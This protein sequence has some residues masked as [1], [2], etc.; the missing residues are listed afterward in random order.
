MKIITKIFNLSKSFPLFLLFISIS[1]NYNYFLIAQAERQAVNTKIQGSAA[2]IAKKAMV[3]IDE[4]LREEYPSS[5]VI[6]PAPRPRRKLRNS[7][8]NCDFKG[9]YLVLQ[10][11]DELLFEVKLLL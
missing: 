3:L 1:F 6:F 11:H 9:A 4:K 2:D 5:P 8:S 10:L 7:G